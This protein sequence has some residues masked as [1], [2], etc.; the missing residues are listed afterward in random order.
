[1]LGSP[2]FPLFPFYE[3]TAVDQCRGTGGTKTEIAAAARNENDTR[4]VRGWSVRRVYNE[5]AMERREMRRRNDEP[6]LRLLINLSTTTPS[7]MQATDRHGPREE[8]VVALDSHAFRQAT[9]HCACGGFCIAYSPETVVRYSR[10]RQSRR[11]AYRPY[12][13]P[14]PRALTCGQH[15]YA[16]LICCLMV[17][18][19]VTHVIRWIITHLPTPEGWKAELVSLHRC[20][21]LKHTGRCRPYNKR[22][23][24]LLKILRKG[25]YY[26]CQLLLFQ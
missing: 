3:T 22:L 15:P 4:A 13:G 14:R 21:Y 19:L 11:T 17:A 20:F 2:A 5:K 9:V 8:V 16:T 23:Q 12:A 24:G 6:S 10:H 18:T 7:E 25:I 1:V 26:G